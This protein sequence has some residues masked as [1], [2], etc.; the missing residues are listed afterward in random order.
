M[1]RVRKSV[2]SR[3]RRKKFLK[4]ASGYRSGR[5]RLYRSA[6]EAVEKALTFAYRD[7]KVRKREF[8]ALWIVRINAALRPLGMS[9][10]KFIGGLKKA[11]I[12]L[13]RKVLADM[14]LYDP[15]GFAKVAELSKQAI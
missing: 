4:M 13:D 8:R 12:N 10:S 15:S 5:R 6:R 7:R 9:Y 1:P 2:A 3:A 11:Q 14:A